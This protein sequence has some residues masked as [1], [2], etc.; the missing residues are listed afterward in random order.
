MKDVKGLEEN[1]A[2][3]RPACDLWGVEGSLALVLRTDAAPEQVTNIL[4]N[5]TGEQLIVIAC[6][7]SY[8][9]AERQGGD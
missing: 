5:L 1:A 4:M 7:V 9:V 6:V 3:L 2:C 8:L